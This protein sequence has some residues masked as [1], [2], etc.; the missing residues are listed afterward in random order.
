METIKM[1]C[2]DGKVYSLDFKRNG[3]SNIDIIVDI[4][5]KKFYIADYNNETICINIDNVTS[6]SIDKP[7]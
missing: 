3:K 5:C 1:F 4:T 7:V 2:I 6:I